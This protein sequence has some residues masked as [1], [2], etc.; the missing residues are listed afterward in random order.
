VLSVPERFWAWTA[1][2]TDGKAQRVVSAFTGSE[3]AL[4]RLGVRDGPDRWVERLRALRP[5]LAVEGGEVVLATWADDPWSRGAYS[6][7]PL[8]WDPKD[9][10]LLARPLGRLHFAGEHTAGQWAGSMEGALRSGLRAADEILR[11]SVELAAQ[12]GC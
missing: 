8:G 6:T 10:D 7:R 2:S 9:A 12:D 1:K 11:W 5:E 4:D 3:A